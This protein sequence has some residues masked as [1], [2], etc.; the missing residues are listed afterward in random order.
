MRSSSGATKRQ[1]SVASAHAPKRYHFDRRTTDL[2][3]LAPGKDGDDLLSTKQVAA[4]LG[5]SE[6]WLEAA[7]KHNYGPAWRKFGP[8]QIRYR[9]D[10]VLQFLEQRDREYRARAEA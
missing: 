7:R 5:I 9:R 8:R 6:Q 4:W 1:G 10:A 2:I 3:N